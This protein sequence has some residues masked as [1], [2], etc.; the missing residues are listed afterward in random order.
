MR[1]HAESDDLTLLAEVLEGERVIA[2]MA[3]N[4]KESVGPSCTTLR[5]GVKMLQL[6]YL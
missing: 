5:I 2:L 1:R 4:N 3:V 6:T